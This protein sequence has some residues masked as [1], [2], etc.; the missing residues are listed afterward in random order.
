MTE[1]DRIFS[2]VNGTY[3]YEV[4]ADGYTTKKSSFEINNN[5]KTIYVSLVKNDQ[6][7]SGVDTSW[8]N[9]EKTEFTLNTANEFAGLLKLVNEGNDF[10][11]K[12][13]N[14]SN[15]ISLENS[16]WASI[17]NESNKFNGKFDGNS[18]VISNLDADLFGYIGEKGS[19]QNIGIEG[20]GAIATVNKGTIAN[21][22]A[23]TSANIAKTNNGT[24]TN[25]Y[26][27]GKT[28]IGEGADAVDSYAIDGETYKEEDLTNSKIADLLNKNVN[29]KN[30]SY[31]SWEVSKEKT[32]LVKSYNA[33]FK[34][35]GK[36]G[37]INDANI[38]LYDKDNNEINADSSKNFMADSNIFRLTNGKYKYVI[39][40][41]GYMIEKGTLRVNNKDLTVELELISAFKINFVVDPSD[42]TVV[43]KDSKN[44]VM[45][46][47]NGIYLLE[48]GEYSYEISKEGYWTE[49]GK[50]I[51]SKDE[52][53]N[54]KLVQTYDVVFKLNVENP[55][56]LDGFELKVNSDNGEEIAPESDKLTY[57]LKNGKYTYTI[58]ATG[59]KEITGEIQVNGESI[60][61]EV[62]FEAS[63]DISW[64][65]SKKD[66]F[67]IENGAQLA[68]LA[69]L[70]NR[71]TGT[72]VSFNGK[73]INLKNDIS[74]TERECDWFPIAK[75]DQFIGKF[76]G[77]NH[78][79]KNL[80]LDRENKDYIGLFGQTSSATLKDLTVEGKVKGRNYVGGLIGISYS[81]T[82]ENCV[83]K[84]EVEGKTYV[85]G[86]V[87]QSSSIINNCINESNIQGQNYIG[88]LVGQNSRN[89]INSYNKGNI[90]G[91]NEGK[92]SCAGGIAGEHYVSSNKDTY[93]GNCYNL[94]N[95]TVKG[96]GAGGIVGYLSTAVREQYLKMYNNYNLGTI[97]ADED[98]GS[99]IGKHGSKAPI[100]EN[101]YDCY[102]LDTTGTAID[103][104]VFPQ[105]AKTE[106]EFKDGTVANLLN[107]NQSVQNKFKFWKVIDDVTTFSDSDK[108]VDLSFSLNPINATVI[109]RDSDGKV[110]PKI[111]ENNNT[112][113]NLKEN[114]TYTYEVKC[115]TY[116]T[117]TK[118]FT[119]NGESTLI[120]VELEYI[121]T[122][123]SFK[124]NVENTQVKVYNN[125]DK[126]IEPNEKGVYTL[127]PGEYYYS[128]SAENYGL[129]MKKFTVEIVKEATPMEINLEMPE[130]KISFKSNT[131][132]KLE[133]VLTNSEGFNIP[134]N[135]DNTVLLSKGTYTYKAYADGFED[136]EGQFTVEDS[137]TISLEMNRIYDVDWYDKDKNEFTLNTKDELVG[138][139]KI[140]GRKTRHI[141]DNF[142]GKTIK[143]GKNI[144]INSK[145]LFT[146]DEKGNTVVSKDAQKWDSISDFAGTFDGCEHSVDGLCGF[147]L[148]SDLSGTV[149]NL[150]TTGYIQGSANVAGISRRTS[151]GA[152]IENCINECDIKATSSYSA[153]IVSNGSKGTTIK[154][155]INKGN[156][157]GNNYASG[158]CGSG[159][160]ATIINCVNEGN[161][162]GKKYI[163]GI[164]RNTGNITNC[165]NLGDVTGTTAAGIS[166]ATT[167]TIDNCINY[168][169]VTGTTSEGSIA[170]TAIRDSITNSYYLKN[171]CSQGIV[172]DDVEG[173]VEGKSSKE[174]GDGSVAALLNTKVTNEN[175][176]KSWTVID[177][178]TV[179][180]SYDLA[181]TPSVTGATVK[182]Y[183]YKGNEIKAIA[184]T[185]GVFDGLR[186]GSLYKYEVTKEGL[187]TEEGTVI[188]GSTPQAIY[189]ELSATVYVTVSKD[190][191]FKL[192][193][194][195]DT[196]LT[197]IPVTTTNF[198]V[199]DYGYPSIYNND[200]Y[201]TLL[202]VFI[203]FHELYSGG[204]DNFA[205]TP[206]NNPAKGNDLFVTKFIGIETTQ[207]NYYV[208][209]KYPGEWLEDKGY[210]WGSAA[211]YIEMKNNDD[212][213]VTL[214]TNYQT[215][216]FY[217]YFDKQEA[218]VKQ[219]QNLELTLKGFNNADAYLAPEAK[220]ISGS[221]IYIDG[222][223]TEIVTDKDGKAT[224]T[225][226][227]PGT[228]IISAQGTDLSLSDSEK[229]VITAPVCEVTVTEADDITVSFDADN[230]SEVVTKAMKPGK[231]LNYMPTA[232]TKEGYTFVGWYKDTDDITT[233]YKQGSRFT[234]STTYKA[235]YAHVTMLGAQG[236]MV[237]NGKSGIRFGTKIYND[238]DEIVEKGTLIL[239]ANLLAEGETL[240]LDTPNVAK[241]VANTLY[242]VNKEQNYL[243][244]LGT[245]V[246][247]PKAQFERQMT[248]SAYVVYKDKAGH[249]YTVY[250]PY[251][252]GSVSV[253]D[254]LGNDIDW[255]EDW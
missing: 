212:V 18:A 116:V 217:T 189:V 170:N 139:A 131:T 245:I 193:D 147:A 151:E 205:G 187:N 93:I 124:S 143:L 64:Y 108:G 163:S 70:T 100:S 148:F 253:L 141:K 37:A 6:S 162:S 115:D 49:K 246:N 25:T 79:I 2:L 88:G 96:S 228:Y 137:Q 95:I 201:P 68:G 176:Y 244:Y 54:V 34:L 94:G 45:D 69:V 218:T 28:V 135:E 14:L 48:D 63:Y 23:L 233:E 120:S 36:N 145:D 127:L 39:S 215:P 30:N 111:R 234:Q 181:I 97:K 242:E 134:V 236:K 250:A 112:Y 75:K 51:V 154:N 4:S 83:N 89:I 132:T 225:F 211:D 33:T 142:E 164:S 174:L 146:K 222:E 185:T 178:K 155:C 175:D 229:T 165:Y 119:Y 44:E 224:L 103:K 167:G 138:L 209:N 230:G 123:V 136:V 72:R 84:V 102:Y 161:V 104:Q 133:V 203:R 200:S 46:T 129:I 41:D 252:N 180:G 62:S 90:T 38:T 179:F 208:N 26:T 110:V 67:D 118:E 92:D 9:A 140:T 216:M 232:P 87:G 240:T 76:Y 173:K 182:L 159:T 195:Q 31:C 99:I 249:Q 98:M 157:S 71:D 241:S 55:T 194:D 207:L 239:P 169:K 199:T 117:Q 150:T 80:V 11:G 106:A 40:R 221:T 171:S 237:S 1:E 238:G 156:I 247:I 210:I 168:G 122:D 243:T 65:D 206:N 186:K 153:G 152:T 50:F 107:I 231:V 22:Y 202:N 251:A 227:E 248:A 130:N 42:A 32:T 7:L 5:D 121:P 191:E 158:I 12:T 17:G 77:N 20:T 166:A 184:G 219:G 82:I 149:K 114:E 60:T 197:R 78:T 52:D 66:S 16:N 172:G 190:G 74:L 196:K 8:Y 226:D 109:L 19:V 220:N 125:K 255:G 235:K 105:G 160:E 86:L 91:G 198:D 53:I 85:G 188:M 10:T 223:E 29:S 61:K 35:T 15:D 21:S 144:E 47:T 183:D 27:N 57:K 128:A 101:I 3:T 24:V 13:I 214:F 204:A 43:V 73:T 113:I 254:L 56:E 59:Y 126:L 177:G 192:A 213:N 58:N 81:S